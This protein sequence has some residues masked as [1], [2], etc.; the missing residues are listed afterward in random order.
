MSFAVKRDLFHIFDTFQAY[1][2]RTITA[3]LRYFLFWHLSPYALRTLYWG[4]FWGQKHFQL[5]RFTAFPIFII[6]IYIK[7]ASLV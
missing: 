5:V 4:Q 2:N 6:P 7:F 1:A 3:I